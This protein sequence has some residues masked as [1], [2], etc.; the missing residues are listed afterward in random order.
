VQRDSRCRFAKTELLAQTGQRQDEVGSDSAVS[1]VLK[2]TAARHDGGDG[3]LVDHLGDRVAQQH[4][5]LVEGLDLPLQL[6][7]VDQIDGH[8]H[9]LTAQS[10]QERVL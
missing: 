3:V 7:A 4:H 6:D 8:R 10:V 2:F 5:V 9:M 1:A